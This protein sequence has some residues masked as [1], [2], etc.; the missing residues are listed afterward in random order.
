MGESADMMLDGTMDPETGEFNFDG[1]DGPGF[2][3]TGEQAAR[4]RD[5]F[6]TPP[7]LEGAELAEQTFPA[8]WAKARAMTGK[9]GQ[10]LRAT[11]RKRARHD[12]RL[13]ELQLA[14]ASCGDCANR[15][16]RGDVKGPIC[17]LQSDFHGY[18]SVGLSDLCVDWTARKQ[19]PASEAGE[20][21]TT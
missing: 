12:K 6:G 7:D 5:G 13:H 9:K 18:V 3:L 17:E 4:Y 19:N 21:E 20:K 15:G 2:L 11:I 14:G 16:R 8:E 10:R 1:Y